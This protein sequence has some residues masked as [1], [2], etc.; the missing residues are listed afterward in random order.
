MADRSVVFFDLVGYSVVAEDLERRAGNAQQALQPLHEDIAAMLDGALAQVGLSRDQTRMRTAADGGLAVF[1][2][3]DLGYLFAAALHDQAAL[4]NRSSTLWERCFRI[5]IGTGDFFES[6]DSRVDDGGRVIIRAARIEPKTARG[7][8]FIDQE[9]RRRLSPEW[10]ERFSTTRL[11]LWVKHGVE[12]EVHVWIPEARESPPSSTEV[13]AA[14]RARIESQDDCERAAWTKRLWDDL[15]KQGLLP[16]A[17][18][19]P[20]V[21]DLARLFCESAAQRTRALLRAIYKAGAIEPEARF[22]AADLTLAAVMASL[23]LEAI[24]LWKPD[25]DRPQAYAGYIRSK[26]HLIAAAAIA[27][28]HGLTIQLSD[29]ACNLPEI[30][31]SPEHSD[32]K[33]FVV[34]QLHAHLISS[35]GSVLATATFED[36]CGDVAQALNILWMRDTATAVVLNFADV[37]IETIKH[38]IEEVAKGINQ[39]VLAYAAEGPSP[40]RP[41]STFRAEDFH[42]LL[43]DLASFYGSG[44]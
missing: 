12:I 41:Q 36:L 23:D 19:N 34:S 31:L 9:T 5:G 1:D 37:P 43:R 27:G 3:A 13:L 29:R 14:I 28:W 6:A 30:R 2:T 8:I 35:G 17:R 38:T 32:Y 4:R 15:L 22:L 42:A 20:K 11:A 44:A 18:A 16:A 33:H 25:P 10:R 40:V 21:A 7:S 26:S 39:A 24:D